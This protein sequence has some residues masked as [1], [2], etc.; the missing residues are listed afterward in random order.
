LEAV[1]TIRHQSILDWKA[2][3][4]KIVGHTCSYVP[5]EIFLAARMLAVRLRGIGSQGLQIGDAYFGPYV[6]SFPKCL[7]QLAGEGR[8]A[9]LDGAIITPGCDSMR[10]LEECW[11]KAGDDHHGIVPDFFY[12]FDV[13]HKTEPH[14]LAWFENE[15]RNLIGAVETHF[16]IRISAQQLQAAI[17]TCNRGR[18]LLARMAAIRA[19]SPGAISGSDAFAITVAGTVMPREEYTEQLSQYLKGIASMSKPAEPTGKKRLMVMGSICDDLALIELIEAG[20]KAIVAAE[21]LCFGVRPENIEIDETGDPVRALAKG[22]LGQST[23]PRMFGKY[24]ARLASV[25]KVIDSAKIDGV[26]LQNIRFCDL[27]GSENSLFERDLEA[28]G[29]PCLK[30]EREYGPL[31]ETGRVKMRLDAF[32]ERIT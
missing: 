13:P 24:R 8:F 21:N 11:R 20:G 15:I 14:G 1:Q 26:I 25:R 10:R 3:G 2:A 19:A 6:C 30:I 16:K 31:V 9:F 32:L 28:L 5:T 27:H 12:Y 4:R 18:R 7:L 22:Y 23:C 17:A 29:I